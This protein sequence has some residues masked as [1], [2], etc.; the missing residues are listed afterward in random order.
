MFIWLQ[1]FSSATLC[2][3]IFHAVAQRKSPTQRAELRSSHNRVTSS[4]VHKHLCA[5]AIEFNA[6][7]SPKSRAHPIVPRHLKCR[8][9]PLQ[10]TISHIACYRHMI[11]HRHVPIPI[12]CGVWMTTWFCFSAEPPYYS[13]ARA[14]VEH[15]IT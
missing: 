8:H 7:Y 3:M 1:C 4:E 11:I 14:L 9:I 5:G 13:P 2:T 15:Q 12:A 10:S 6:V